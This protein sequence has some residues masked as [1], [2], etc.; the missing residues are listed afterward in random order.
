MTLLTDNSFIRCSRCSTR[1][2]FKKATDWNIVYDKGLVAGFLCGRCI[3]D[4]EYTEAE[5]NAATLNY[6]SATVDRDGRT[7]VKGVES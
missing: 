1:T 5:I 7:R 4:E 3:T 6:S 2:K